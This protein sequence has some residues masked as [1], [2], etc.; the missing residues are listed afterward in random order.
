M[1]RLPL[2][3]LKREEPETD[4]LRLEYSMNTVE[5]RINIFNIY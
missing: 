3:L 2:T 1:N 4:V 5:D